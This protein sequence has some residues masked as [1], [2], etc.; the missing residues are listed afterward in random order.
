MKGR[1]TSDTFSLHDEGWTSVLDLLGRERPVIDP[2]L[3]LPEHGPGSVNLTQLHHLHHDLQKVA[4]V[5]NDD[6]I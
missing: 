5:Q 4:R 1:N 3:C 6:P 2:H